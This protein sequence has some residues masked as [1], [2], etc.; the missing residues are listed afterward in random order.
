[1]KPLL[2]II[3]V[4]IDITDQIPNPS[5]KQEDLSDKLKKD[6]KRKIREEIRYVTE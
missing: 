6:I 2:K 3:G 5:T 4:L 1:M